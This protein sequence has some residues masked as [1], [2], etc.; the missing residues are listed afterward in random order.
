M[1]LTRTS[2]SMGKA[3]LIPV[4][5]GSKRLRPCGPSQTRCNGDD[6]Q[7]ELMS[8]DRVTVLSPQVLRSLLVSMAFV[9][10]FALCASAASAQDAQVVS[11]PAAS[12]MTIAELSESVS[13][14]LASLREFESYP[15]PRSFE[16]R[17][18]LEIRRDEKTIHLLGRI[19][20]LADR[21]LAL[22]AI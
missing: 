14:K 10:V 1:S 3:L 11:V 21:V 18:T 7:P 9:W 19:M 4:W 22:P 20:S 12:E 13:N 8:G 2:W 6:M 16:R 17:R 15:M 5:I